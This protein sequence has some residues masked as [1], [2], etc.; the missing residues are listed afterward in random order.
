MPTTRLRCRGFTLIESLVASLVLAI[1]V[2][3]ISGVFVTVS[4]STSTSDASLLAAQRSQAN[5][6]GLAAKRFS[7]YATASGGVTSESIAASHLA[8]PSDTSATT[9]G[10]ITYVSRSS[11]QPAHDIGVVSVTTT[12][13][14]GSYVTLYRL[15]T[16]AEMIK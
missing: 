15:V 2:V 3:G 16:R 8:V 10:K 9:S 1:C 11:L 4:Q 12:T 5:L 14:E 6:E 13:P 7:D